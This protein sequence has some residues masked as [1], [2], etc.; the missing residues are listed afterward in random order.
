[1]TY[2]TNDTTYFCFRGSIDKLI[3]LLTSLSAVNS[4]AG[5]ETK[6]TVSSALTQ[7]KIFSSQVRDLPFPISVE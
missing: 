4:P 5:S 1:M 7:L 6:A 2:M 3:V